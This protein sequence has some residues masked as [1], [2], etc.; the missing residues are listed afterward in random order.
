MYRREASGTD[1]ICISIRGVDDFASS[2]CSRLCGCLGSRWDSGDDGSRGGDALNI[3][4]S[5]G[6]RRGAGGAGDAGI[7]TSSDGESLR[8]SL[9]LAVI[10]DYG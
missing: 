9:V 10:V 6:R 4:G 5:G 7:V 1:A 3:V 8:P 2:R